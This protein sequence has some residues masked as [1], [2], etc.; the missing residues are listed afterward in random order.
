MYA[1][2]VHTS[3]HFHTASYLRHAIMESY[4]QGYECKCFSMQMNPILECKDQWKTL[5]SH[6]CHHEIPCTTFYNDF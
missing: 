5:K 3:V 2:Y 4:L 1:K 6:K